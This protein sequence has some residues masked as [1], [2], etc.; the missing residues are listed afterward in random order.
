M[1]ALSTQTLQVCRHVI[2][3]QVLSVGDP[4][5]EEAARLATQALRELDLTIGE[6]IAQAVTPEEVPDTV[7][8]TPTPGGEEGPAALVAGY[9]ASFE[10][11][12][13]ESAGAGPD[14]D[15]PYQVV[16]GLPKPRRTPAT[17]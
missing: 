12:V 6:R 8:G 14:P 7:G 4:G 1:N 16:T 5:F 2:A 15:Y 11:V 3:S 17:K 13:S 10:P 9:E